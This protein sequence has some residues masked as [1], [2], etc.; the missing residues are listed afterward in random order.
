DELE[1]IE[2]E[3]SRKTRLWRSIQTFEEHMETW[4][5]T[6]FQDLD[7][8]AM[9]TEVGRFWR[10]VQLSEKQLPANPAVGRLKNMVGK[11]KHTVPVVA[12]LRSDTLQPRHWDLL[13]GV[14]D[15]DIS[16]GETV[17]FKQMM[18][19]N[20][21]DVADQVSSV[22]TEA[23]QESILTRTLQK[24]Q[25]SWSEATF[26]LKPHKDK[27]D[28]LV[29]CGVN[30]LTGRVDD[31]VVALANVVASPYVGPIRS[32]AEKF[33]GKLQTLQVC[34]RKCYATLEEWLVFQRTWG[35]LASIFAAPDIQK[36][37]P[38]EARAFR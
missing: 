19:S 1:E 14:L 17:S 13:N 23:E 37:I 24:V 20:L 27:K 15:V 3:T 35:Y 8:A 6:P 11:V 32:E 9:E 34:T 16:A 12:D 38:S 25:E 31:S 28:V 5:R 2:V 26:Q 4:E 22:V 18:E 21:K 10:V 30:D 33:A 29:L 7:I 36:Q